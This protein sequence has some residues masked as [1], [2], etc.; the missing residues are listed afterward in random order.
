MLVALDIVED[1]H[2]PK[3]VGEFV[4]RPERSGHESLRLDT[5]M[6]RVRHHGVQDLI[7][8]AAL[9]QDRDSARRVLLGR[10]EGFVG[11]P[12]GRVVI[13]VV[14]LVEMESGICKRC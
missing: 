6:L 2:D 5:G 10:A 11:K 4:H 1:E 8:P 3:D 14:D 12:L 9:P 13:D 7:R